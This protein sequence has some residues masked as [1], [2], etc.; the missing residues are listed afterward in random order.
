M[1]NGFSTFRGSHFDF[2][3]PDNSD[4]R[5]QRP[6]G[7]PDPQR[8][9]S[10]TVQLLRTIMHDMRQ[11]P[12]PPGAAPPSY[13]PSGG[14]ETPES[15]YFVCTMYA[16]KPTHVQDMTYPQDIMFFFGY[17]HDNSAIDP[18]TGKVV[19]RRPGFAG[20]ASVKPV[21]LSDLLQTGRHSNAAAY[22]NVQLRYHGNVDD[23]HTLTEMLRQCLLSI[24]AQ[25]DSELKSPN[26]SE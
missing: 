16:D 26:N 2:S 25:I 1:N 14:S 17:V 21:R 12:L 13:L 11:H 19:L 4:W 23:G 24:L 15:N 22:N 3:E 9:R 10:S 7:P 20:K 8:M 6:E 18:Y 5:S